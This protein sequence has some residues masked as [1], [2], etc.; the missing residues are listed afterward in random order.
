MTDMIDFTPACEALSAVVRA[1]PDDALGGPTPCAKYTVGDLLSH[2]SGLPIAFKAAAVKQPLGPPP[3]ADAAN[4][5][6]EWRKLIPRDLAALAEA[7]KEPSAWEGMSGAGGIELPAAVAGITG[8]DEVVVHAWDLARSTGQPYTYEGPGLDAIAE[9]LHAFR[10]MGV[11]GIFGPEFAVP[12]TAPLF[13][14]VL[15]LTG[16]DPA[17]RPPAG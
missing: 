1:L 3:A 10:S 4:L 17:W 11:E 15:G 16:R 13:D 6:P 5:D 2:V 7:W 12:D 14:Q 9:Q 8:L